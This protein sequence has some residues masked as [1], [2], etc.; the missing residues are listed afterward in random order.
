MN[1]CLCVQVCKA[2]IG[3]PSHLMR[4]GKV[5][6]DVVSPS[7]YNANPNGQEQCRRI[8]RSSLIQLFAM[9]EALLH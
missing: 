4:S 5:I 9:A 2:Y 3:H 1:A 7:T 8:F 6:F